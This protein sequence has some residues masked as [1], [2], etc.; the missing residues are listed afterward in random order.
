VRFAAKHRRE[1]VSYIGQKEQKGPPPQGV[2]ADIKYTTFLP[3]LP[4]CA[5]VN[6]ARRPRK[7]EV[8]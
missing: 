4:M 8:T 2:S 3:T 1:F 7:G 6:L 5:A